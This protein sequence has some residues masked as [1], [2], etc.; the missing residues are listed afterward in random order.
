MA[1]ADLLRGA[2]DRVQAFERK[3]EPSRD[4]EHDRQLIALSKKDIASGAAEA[5]HTKEQM[6]A[7]F[8]VGGWLHMERF[9]IYQPH[10]DIWRAI[11]NGKTFHNL[12][13]T[14]YER[15]HTTSAE[16]CIAAAKEIRQHTPDRCE[17]T[18]LEGGVEM[19]KA[20]TGALHPWMHTSASTWR[21]SSTQPA[22]RWYTYRCAPMLSVSPA[23][24]TI[25]TVCRA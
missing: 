9:V 8:G 22:S 20:R 12:S 7:R 21:I 1:H 24:Y 16:W 6:D 14:A 2:D 19:R 3:A 17:D 4:P 11:D 13:T 15:V 23:L 18:T 25:I 5:F 10:S